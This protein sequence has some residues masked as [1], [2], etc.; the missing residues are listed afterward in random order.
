MT[1]Q[2]HRKSAYLTVGST[3]TL[4]SSMVKSAG[5]EIPSILRAGPTRRRAKTYQA[6]SVT[7]CALEMLQNIV[8]LETYSSYT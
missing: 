5:A 6:P 1:Q 8:A 2:C 3:S 7:L 4:V